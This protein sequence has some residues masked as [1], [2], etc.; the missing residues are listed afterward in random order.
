MPDSPSVAFFRDVDADPSVL[1]GTRVT[2]VGYGNLGAAVAAN[3]VDSGVSV[4]VGNIDDA[5]RRQAKADGFRVADIAS[6]V[7]RADLVFLLIPDEV[8]AACYTD[9]VAPAIRP[10][11]A[12]CFASGYALAYGLVEPSEELDVVLCAPRMLGEEVRRTYLDGTGFVSYVSVE[13]DATGRGWPLVLALARAVG[14]LQRG[15][16]QLSAERE[17]QLDLFVE[18]GLGAYIGTAIQLSFQVGVEAGL[19]PEALV[20]EMYMSGEMARTFQ[21]FAEAGFYRSTA[22]H[23]AVAQYGGYLRTT[24]FDTDAVQEFLRTVLSEITDGSFAERFQAEQRAGYP[25]LEVINQMTAGNDPMS[26]AEA[27]VSQALGGDGQQGADG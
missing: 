8:M 22:W 16:M 5:Y 20:L 24:A 11:A 21:T 19:P 25:T 2:V 27:R 7:A 9:S 17:A 13:H 1:A 4:E 14:S 26:A 10:G 3:L 12:L 23:G 15:A 6:A 18:Q